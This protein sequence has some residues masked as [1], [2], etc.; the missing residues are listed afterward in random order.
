MFRGT[1]IVDVH[2]KNGKV[3][4]VARAHSPGLMDLVEIAEQHA[5]RRDRY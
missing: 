5:G 1:G 2:R 3:D 4:L